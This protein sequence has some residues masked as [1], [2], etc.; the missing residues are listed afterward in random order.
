MTF[1]M[2]A[3]KYIKRSEKHCKLC[4]VFVQDI[5]SH[6]KSNKHKMEIEKQKKCNKMYLL[7]KKPVISFETDFTDYEPLKFKYEDEIF[8][9]KHYKY[10]KHK[11]QLINLCDRLII[12][13]YH[14]QSQREYFTIRHPK[15]MSL[16][17]DDIIL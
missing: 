7:P 15:I 4:D 5:K 12:R 2:D 13:Q 9:S 17:V 3:K 8:V 1:K 6:V 11:R 16:F 14:T 10:N